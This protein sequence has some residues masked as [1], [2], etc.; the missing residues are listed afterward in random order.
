M[1]LPRGQL[2]GVLATKSLSSRDP[3]KLASGI[4]AYLLEVGRVSELPSILRDIQT[5]WAESGHVDAQVYS[6]FPLDD[7]VKK[8]I[9]AQ[10]SRIYPNAKTILITDQIDPLV[11]S[12]VRIE[13]P[14]QLLDLSVDAKIRRF[15]QL[16]NS[17][18]GAN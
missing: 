16:T 7:I 10:V 8:D 3:K 15:K 4:A 17:Q 14:N 5:D 6:A 2:S 9:H 12:G 13:L 18:G 1:K 11:I